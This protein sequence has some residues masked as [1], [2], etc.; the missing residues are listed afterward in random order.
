[1]RK[2]K[3][4]TTQDTTPGFNKHKVQDLQTPRV[5]K[6]ARGKTKIAQPK[7]PAWNSIQPFETSLGENK[8][9]STKK[10]RKVEI[11]KG[12]IKCIPCDTE[13]SQYDTYEKHECETTQDIIPDTKTHKVQELQTP[14]HVMKLKVIT[15]IDSQKGP[16]LDP[17][18]LHE[19]S[20]DQPKEENI[21]NKVVGF[22][23]DTT[24]NKKTEI[25]SGMWKCIPCGREFPQQRIYE[26]HQREHKEGTA[27][28]CDCKGCLVKI[29]FSKLGLEKHKLEAHGIEKSGFECEHCHKVF[30]SS[31]RRIYKRHLTKHSNIKDFLCMECGK[32]FKVK[33]GLT[34]HMKKHNNFF[35]HE[36]KTC[37]KKFVSK[38]I[39]NTHIGS[40][41]TE[42]SFACEFCGNKFNTKG[43]L[44]THITSHTGEKTKSCS[45]CDKKFRRYT[46][47][48]N[49]ENMH[50]NIK[51]YKCKLCP[52]EFV[53]QYSLY[54]H[55]KRHNNQRDH[56]CNVCTK[57]FIDPAG[58]R[59]HKCLGPLQGPG[60]S[61]IL[62]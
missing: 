33:Q 16:N 7:S 15:T 2:H 56:V 19:V 5:D 12:K 31:A 46:Q 37:G 41:H 58:L 8:V 27:F 30:K 26:K 22:V 20:L 23:V 24:N 42:A 17:F 52:K 3:C 13:F 57:G 45:F 32:A 9:V 55:M 51:N 44:N 10:N 59:K 61:T 43:S 6:E 34:F 49:H 40:S 60:V 1:M 28:P 39:L 54:I 36:C 35:D 11:R 18:Q 4:G 50:R 48:K 62:K 14:I 47:L 53:K 38:G 21:D 29:I 25:I